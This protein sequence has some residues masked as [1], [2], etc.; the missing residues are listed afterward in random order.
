MDSPGRDKESNWLPVGR[1]LFTLLMR[2]Y[3]PKAGALNG[4]WRP[5]DVKREVTKA[6]GQVA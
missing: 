2:L 6:V 5:P 1:E 3:S 4:T